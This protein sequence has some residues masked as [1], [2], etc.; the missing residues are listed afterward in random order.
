[1]TGG[2]GQGPRPSSLHSES[3]DRDGSPPPP[4]SPWPVQQQKQPPSRPP[5]YHSGTSRVDE[6]TS[7][8]PPVQHSRERVTIR[9]ETFTLTW[10]RWTA[11]GR[12]GYQKTRHHSYACAKP[13]IALLALLT[14]LLLTGVVLFAVAFCLKALWQWGMSI[15]PKPAPIP[16]YAVAIIGMS[17]FL[18]FLNLPPFQPYTYPT[19]QCLTSLFY[20][21]GAGPAGI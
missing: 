9:R 1:M 4:Y 7:L 17:A 14:T 15:W 21:L 16:T 19:M 2:S 5:A 8:L 13:C 18:F 11:S 3:R 10:K 6:R 12:R 20:T